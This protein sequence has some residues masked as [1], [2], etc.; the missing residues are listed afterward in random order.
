[1]LTTSIEGKLILSMIYDVK[2]YSL[3]YFDFHELS[4]AEEQYLKVSYTERH[5]NGTVNV[6]YRTEIYLES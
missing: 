4:S 6:E 3:P 2:R 1:M 5:P